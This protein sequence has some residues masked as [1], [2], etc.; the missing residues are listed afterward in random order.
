MIKNYIK[1]AFANLR[2]NKVYSIIS[3]SSLS[4]GFAVCILLLLYVVNELSFDRYHSKADNIYRLCQ[5]EHPFQAP[6]TAQLLEKAIPEIKNSTRI[7][8]REDIL[9]QFNNQKYK[10]NFV[11]WVDAEL[12]D[13]FS[14]EFIKRSTS[15]PLQ[16]PGTAVLT[17]ST[18]LKYFGNKNPIGKNFKVNGEHNYTVVGII[19]DIPKNSHFVFDLFL[20]LEDGD[21]MFEENWM[22][23]WGWLNFFVYF[24]M[25]DEFNKNSLDIKVTEIMHK[26]YNPDNP[27]AKITSYTLQ[28]LKDIHLYSS[29]FLADIQPQN[30]ITY[31]LIFSAIAILIL[32]IASFNYINLLTANA[33]TRLTEI[34]VRKSFGA[35]RIQI[36]K[37]YMAESILVFIISVILSILLV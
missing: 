27:E 7:L 15:K 8:P 35:S 31:V 23:N 4:I 14:F 33:T 37:Q 30:S 10:E 2:K 29:H 32:L 24:E 28:N 12:F 22:E 34:S 19:K 6:G 25:Q 21:K 18:A 5:Q 26:Q 16:E 17:E 11:A 36:A 3:I 1:I 9:V 20:T 13:L